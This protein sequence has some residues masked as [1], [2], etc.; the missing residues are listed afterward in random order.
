MKSQNPRFLSRQSLTCHDW[1]RTPLKVNSRLIIHTVITNGS[2]FVGWCWTC[3]LGV[4]N[5]R[6]QPLA[7]SASRLQCKP[8]EGLHTVGA[9][10]KAKIKQSSHR[11]T[12]PL[13]RHK[14]TIR[15]STDGPMFCWLYQNSLPFSK[16]QCREENVPLSWFQAML[17]Q[18]RSE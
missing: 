12:R 7:I 16:Q 11:E 14:N 1:L 2:K 5:N 15:Q 6:H 8:L 13:Y 17:S 9:P 3:F 4:R 18:G 10:I